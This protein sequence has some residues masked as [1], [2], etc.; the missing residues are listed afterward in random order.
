[1]FPSTAIYPPNAKQAAKNSPQKSCF[2]IDVAA[3][4]PLQVS[5]LF[6]FRSW[7][8]DVQMTSPRQPAMKNGQAPRRARSLDP[9]NSR[10]ACWA[11]RTRGVYASEPPA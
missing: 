11:W 4:T 10:R 3:A 8:R 5:S 1:M 7:Q 9:L 2:M 6:H